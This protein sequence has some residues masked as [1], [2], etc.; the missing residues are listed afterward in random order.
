MVQS[1]CLGMERPSRSPERTVF[2]QQCFQ[3]Q[4]LN[5][6][7][8]TG[9]KPGTVSLGIFIGGLPIATPRP[10][11]ILQGQLS[12]LVPNSSLPPMSSSGQGRHESHSSRAQKDRG[13]NE[14]W[15]SCK[16]VFEQVLDLNLAVVRPLS[17]PV[18]PP[19]LC[20]PQA[21]IARGPL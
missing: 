14:G 20:H 19:S 13:K 2:P 11:E 9:E 1:P 12:R 17:S 6:W 4:E 7:V 21:P 8:G 10:R 5:L 3:F 16:V 18:P 15:A